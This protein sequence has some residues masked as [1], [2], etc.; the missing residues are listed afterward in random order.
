[1]FIFWIG[2]M[3]AFLVIELITVGLTTIW[4][5]GGSLAALIAYGAGLNTVWQ[6]VIFLVV[7]LLLLYFTRP[8]AIKYINPHH[9]KTNYEDA[10]GQIVKITEK[11]DNQA[12]TGTAILNGLEWTARSADDSI[13]FSVD[14]MAKVVEVSGVKLIV[15]ELKA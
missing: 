12:G 5:A 7:S 2:L 4:F 9:V 10:V 3:I 13:T 14:S 11:V 6:V 1:M 15:E 8:W